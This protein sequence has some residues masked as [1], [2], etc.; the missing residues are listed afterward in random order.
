MGDPD[1]DC[2]FFFVQMRDS[3]TKLVTLLQASFLFLLFFPR[4]EAMYAIKEEFH[5]TAGEWRRYR[6]KVIIIKRFSVNDKVL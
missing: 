6:L 4:E 5:W 2:H 1:P 3:F